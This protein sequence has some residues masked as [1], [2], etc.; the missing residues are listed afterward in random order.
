MS[1]CLL[2]CQDTTVYL[3]YDNESHFLTMSCVDNNFTSDAQRIAFA[4]Y[5][6][7]VMFLFPVIV[8][9]YCYAVVTRV[10]WVSTKQHALM[11]RS[12]ATR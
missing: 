7:L 2:L 3:S 10:L 11:T 1:T 8:I 9:V 4:W 12:V 5:Q 6:L